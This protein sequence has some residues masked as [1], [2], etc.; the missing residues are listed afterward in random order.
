MLLAL[1][2]LGYEIVIDKTINVSGFTR[3]DVKEVVINNKTG[4]M[5][6]DDARAKSVKKTW[7]D[8]KTYCKSLKH[9]GFNDW[10]LPSISQLESL[11]DNKKHDPAIKTVFE[12]TV[13][14]DYWSSSSVV[15]ISYGAW[16]AYFKYGY[17]YYSNKTNTYH[18]RCARA[19][20]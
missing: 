14:S 10:Y 4:L 13:S 12:N 1:P 9:A 11:I 18:V 3:D 8:A 17:T 6:Q 19:G 2:S 15:S 7:S 16:N 20:Q 5:W